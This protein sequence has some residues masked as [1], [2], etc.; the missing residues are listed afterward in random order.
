MWPMRLSNHQADPLSPRPQNKLSCLSFSLIR[1]S[2]S[3]DLPRPPESSLIRRHADTAL[4]VLLY[5]ALV[6]AMHC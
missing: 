2:L 5:E 3:C 6:G 1:P 4:R